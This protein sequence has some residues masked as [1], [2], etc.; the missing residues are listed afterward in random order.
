MS[1]LYSW[2]AMT[3]KRK[4]DD[5]ALDQYMQG[6]GSCRPL[7]ATE[8]RRLTSRMRRLR[9][10]LA[11]LLRDLPE[12]HRC[13]L[14][15]GVPDGRELPFA[16][17]EG[18]VSWLTREAGERRD[19]ALAAPA[20]RA[21]AILKALASARA[22]LITRNLRLTYHLARRIAG[23]GALLADVIQVGNLGL[24]EAADRFDPG[25][26][27]RFSTYAGTCITGVIIREMPGLLQAV[28]VPSYQ[29]RL[30]SR[31]DQSRRGLAQDLR[32]EP[33]LAE[34]AAGASLTEQ[35]AHD[36]LASKPTLLN[37]DAPW[38]GTEDRSLAD[39]L[40]AEDGISLQDQ[41]ILNNML[42]HLQDILASLEPR[43]R[44]VLRLR[45]GLD[46]EHP[47]TLR[48]IGDAMNLSKERIRQLEE[49]AMKLLRTRMRNLRSRPARAARRPT[50]RSVSAER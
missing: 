34:T 26:G 8:E 35:K 11:R 25:R 37:L 29:F 5:S 15:G 33:T 12:S 36:V 6:L 20:R 24:L 1:G 13:R 16:Q 27:V 30:R 42:E 32:R 22:T 43:L 18:I 17:L 2:T 48:E 23:G 10:E 46:G 44:T 38:P 49:E 45:Y 39:S 28:R 41:A 21:R 14:L 4:H 40:A 19:T 31:L 50:L 47:R 9:E 3:S 7:E